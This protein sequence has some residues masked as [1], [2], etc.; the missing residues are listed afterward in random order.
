MT[1]KI[2]IISRTIFPKLVPRA[3]RATE[4][5]KELARQGNEVTLAAV[6]GK[7]NY[8]RFQEETGIRVCDLGMS[9]FEWI[10]SDREPKV[11]LYGGK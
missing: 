6:L 8:T 9:G 10:N 7:Y 11:Y 1:Q 2:L 3:H 5:A 4:L